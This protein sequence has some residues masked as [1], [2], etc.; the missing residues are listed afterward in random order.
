MGKRKRETQDPR[1][2]E[3]LA[4]LDTEGLLWQIH[5]SS[6]YTKKIGKI[7]IT[8]ATSSRMLA[9]MYLRCRDYACSS[10]VNSLMSFD[11]LQPGRVYHIDCDNCKPFHI[12]ARVRTNV[13]DPTIEATAE[14]RKFLSFSIL[15]EKNLSHF[16]GR[17]LY[18]YRTGVE[19]SMI[20]YIYEH[21]GDTQEQVETRWELAE[22]P[23]ELLDCSDL[24]ARALKRKTYCQVS[25]ESKYKKPD[26]ASE[27]LRPDAV[28][29]I[30][31]I[32]ADDRRAATMRNLP[33]LILQQGRNTVATIED[34]FF[35]PE[36][37][38]PKY[39]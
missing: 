1:I 31:K 13:E 32:T 35:I 5:G 34:F 28:L 37:A 38:F 16:P 33:I 11:E 24:C 2:T 12:L 36:F 23:K 3:V 15:T 30:N 6:Y 7:H 19:P 20:G 10:I 9:K 17:V 8:Q 14:R 39:L 26:G 27:P 4:N 18:G 25:V 29:A 21:D 22:I